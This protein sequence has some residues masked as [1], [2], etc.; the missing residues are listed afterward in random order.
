MRFDQLIGD[1]WTASND[2]SV[3][4]NLSNTADNIGEFARRGVEDVDIAVAAVRV[5]QPAWAEAN[6]QVSHNVLEKEDMVMVNLP[7]ASVDHILPFGVRKG[8]SYG[9]CEQKS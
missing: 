5:A 2:I 3:N 7:T 4:N 8:S 6:E 9:L 1:K